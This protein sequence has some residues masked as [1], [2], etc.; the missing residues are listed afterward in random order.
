[1]MELS[2][3]A[4]S[5]SS[6]NQRETAPGALFIFRDR[7]PDLF[8]GVPRKILLIAEWLTEHGVF[9]PVLL[10]SRESAFSDAFA[11]LGLP[12]HYT[13][14]TGRGA[15]RRT[16]EAAEALIPKH[17]ITLVQTH[18]FWD[19]IVGRRI[20]KR[21]AELRHLYRVHTH[22][23]GSTIPWWRKLSYH[24]L[25]WW[26]SDSVDFFCALSGVVE[27]EL[28]ARSRIDASKVHVVRNG[29]PPLGA[30]PPMTSGESPIPPRLAIVGQVER[31]KRQDLAV[32]AIKKLNGSGVRAQ[33]TLIGTE[34]RSYGGEIRRLAADLG[35]QDQ[36][37]FSGYTDDVYEA[38]K[39]IE[40]VILPSDFE[41]IPTSIIEAMS[42][43]K[44]VIA[45]SAG[46]T[47]ELIRD[48]ANGLLMPMDDAPKLAH[49]LHDVF[50]SPA[51]KWIPLREAGYRTWKEQYSVRVMMNGLLEQYVAMG[52]LPEGCLRHG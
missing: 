15:V 34:D 23:E 37:A 27:K 51:D 3:N 50:T 19:S 45:T 41:G 25:D 12:V 26:T 24:M 14:M 36:V 9:L 52:L 32:R 13:D 22:I 17:N 39:D 42:V 28:I 10:T 4:K 49:I 43:K 18:T 11:A 46:A 2:E 35:V 7:D 30:A 20:R 29:I 48:G 21:H 33:L 5:Q 31:R 8:G 40:V 16:A 47:A 6:G 38:V 44:L 1:M